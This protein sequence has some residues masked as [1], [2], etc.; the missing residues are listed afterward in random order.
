MGTTGLVIGL[1]SAVLLLLVGFVAFFNWA[2]CA[3]QGWK[4]RRWK[5]LL[6]PKLAQARILSGPYR[7]RRF[8]KGRH[9]APPLARDGSPSQGQVSGPIP[10]RSTTPD[11]ELRLSENWCLEAYRPGTYEP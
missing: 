2:Y 3:Y 10:E 11:L 7:H 8:M 4:D 9:G 1:G 5:R 6:A